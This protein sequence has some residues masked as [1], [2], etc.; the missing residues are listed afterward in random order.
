MKSTR[1]KADLHVKESPFY[2]RQ[3]LEI[4]IMA[5]DLVPKWLKFVL[6]FFLVAY[7][8]GAMCVKYVSGAQSLVEGVSVTIFND[9]NRLQEE[10]GFDPYYLAI[11]IFGVIAI[12]FSFGN[13]ENAKVLQIVTTC[14]RFITTFLMMVGS[15]ISFGYEGVSSPK[16]WIT[17]DLDYIH[18]LFG[19]TIFVF[20]C[21]HSVSGIVYP[22][23]PQSTIKPMFFW[24]FLIGSCTLLLEATLAMLAF[25]HI[26]NDSCDEFPCEIQ[27][28]YN[29]NFANLPVIGQIVN[30]Y[31]M[32]NVAAVPILTITL[33]NNLFQLF[34]IEGKQE[35]TRLKKG[36]WSIA[37][38][39][40]VVAVTLFYRDAQTLIT[41][42]GGLTGMVILLL[43]PAAFVQGSRRL[44]FEDIHGKTNHNNSPFKH[45]FWPFF[46]YG[47]SL[48]TLGVVIYG[49]F[50]GGGGH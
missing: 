22:V 39:L 25:S 44:G 10:I 32:L 35:V 29:I 45:A 15:M 17:P 31:P 7:M 50:K 21:H 47:F 26:E 3:K 5:E 19:N 14:L 18:L 4:G 6:F 34:G 12:Y 49:I 41:Y 20:I 24:S 36:L 37:L 38:S 48:I 16:D 11:I 40:P 28:L 2:I 43:I 42:T 33:R 23:R 8:Y 30:F 13:I 9:E 1:D 27:K 46:I